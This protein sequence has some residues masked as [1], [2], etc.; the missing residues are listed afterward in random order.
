MNSLEEAGFPWARSH[1]FRKTVA[2]ELNKG[3]DRLPG[4]IANHLGHSDIGSTMIYMDRR[5]GSPRAATAL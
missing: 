2:T 3:L 1:T 5:Q 4:E